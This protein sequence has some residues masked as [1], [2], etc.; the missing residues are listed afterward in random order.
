M[1]NGQITSLEVSIQQSLLVIPRTALAKSGCPMSGMKSVTLAR[2]QR[3]YCQ[4]KIWSLTFLNFDLDKLGLWPFTE[5][6][7]EG[8]TSI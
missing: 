1:Y 2:T 5:L 8:T 3:A 6:I 7:E 4:V